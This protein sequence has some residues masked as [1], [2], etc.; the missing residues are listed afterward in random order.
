MHSASPHGALWPQNVLV[1]A[2]G[3]ALLEVKVAELEAALLR[4]A[5]REWHRL[6]DS[7]FRGALRLPGYVFADAESRLGRFDREARTLELS[8]R[9]ALREPWTALVEVLKHEMAHQYVTEILGEREETAHGP[10]LVHTT[11]LSR[12][13]W[14]SRLTPWGATRR[15]ERRWRR[16]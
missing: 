1:T 12:P 4:E 2:R 3:L 5:R 11:L 14:P 10:K 6:N 16:R 9:L 7:H 8:R 15:C 13:N